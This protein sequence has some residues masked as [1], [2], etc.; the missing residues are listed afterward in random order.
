MWIHQVRMA[1]QVVKHLLDGIVPG[2]HVE[3]WAFIAVTGRMTH[4][5]ALTRMEVDSLGLDA[6]SS[7]ERANNLNGFPHERGNLTGGVVT[8]QTDDEARP[9]R[10]AS[11]RLK[12]LGRKYGEL[13]G[14]PDCCLLDGGLPLC[15]G[16][17]RSLV[18]RDQPG[19]AHVDIH[20]N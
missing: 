19:V 5:A 16:A 6:R 15:S 3:S 20:Q 8:P 14:S 13:S 7:H 17:R 2:L 4:D 18:D 10:K 9:I 11:S 12:S 1:K